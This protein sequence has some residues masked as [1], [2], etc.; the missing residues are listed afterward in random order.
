MYILLDRRIHC[1]LQE[2]I[3]KERLL[4][5]VDTTY[6]Q[7]SIVVPISLRTTDILYA[8]EAHAEFSNIIEKEECGHQEA[9]SQLVSRIY[10]Y[11]T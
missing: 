2:L 10:E 6:T 4:L 9:S 11:M 1:T 8:G 3:I 5:T 7:P